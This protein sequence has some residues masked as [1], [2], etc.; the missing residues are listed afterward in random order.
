MT[1][2]RPRDSIRYDLI[3][4]NIELNKDY[5]ASATNAP[6]DEKPEEMVE[7]REDGWGDTHQDIIDMRR[8][9]KKQEFKA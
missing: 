7:V 3:M 8:L 4:E 5:H 1:V 2:W 6:V 9:G